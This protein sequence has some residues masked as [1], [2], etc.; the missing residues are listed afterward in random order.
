MIAARHL[1]PDVITLHNE[2]LRISVLPCEGAR[3]A[4]IL[5]V[6]SQTEYL[7]Q[8]SVRYQRPESLGLWDRYEKSACAGMDECLPTVTVCGPEAPGGPVPDHGDF[9][10]LN[11]AVTSAPTGDSVSLAATGYS[12]P[13]FF[14][15]SLR[16]HASSLA[17]DYRI[18][19][20]S[21]AQLPFHYAAHPLLAIDEGDRIVL[22]PEICAGRLEG[23]RHNR[24]GFP[25]S[26][27]TWPWPQGTGID[28]SRTGA[29]SDGT[30]EMFYT[31][32]LR[33]GWCG[34]YRARSRQGIVVRFDTAKLPF[35]GLWLCYGGWPE[36]ASLPRQYAIAFEPTAAPWATL[37]AAWE[38][39]QAVRLGPRASFTFN[40]VFELIGPAPLTYDEFVARCSGKA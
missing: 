22:P 6:Q 38:H 37:T 20:L 15:K 36:D 27:I 16:L 2:Q 19:N 3:I 40:I 13:L 24:L 5:N 23:S 21:D 10:R 39:R 34:L 14:Q 4:S 17:I 33:S 32:P 1:S 11:W 26:I 12:R 28:L 7:L 18:S 8:P 25:G 35:L 30:A 31:G 9:W 29:A